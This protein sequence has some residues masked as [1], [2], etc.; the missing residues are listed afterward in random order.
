MF[1]VYNILG[2]DPKL[3][4][5]F[6]DDPTVDY[7]RPVATRLKSLG[8]RG[9]KGDQEFDTYEVLDRQGW[10]DRISREWKLDE[11]IRRVA[12]ADP[13]EFEGCDH[14]QRVKSVFLGSL[15][16]PS[17]CYYL[18]FA[19]SNVAGDCP[20]C[21]GKGVFDNPLH[22]P[23][24]DQQVRSER[25]QLTADNKHRGLF[26]DWPKKAQRRARSLD[27]LIAH[28][29]PTVSCPVCN[30]SGSKSAAEDEAW[31]EAFEELL[32]EHDLSLEQGLNGDPCDFFVARHVTVEPEEEEADV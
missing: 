30:G 23:H 16:N 2:Y 21:A 10:K 28:Y 14:D 27:R 7:G 24:V 20:V 4:L 22:N 19:C 15:I 12:N 6:K 3:V 8:I 29:G 11:I 31:R 26:I 9:P 13:E 18:P 5:V 1:V 32:G 25:A 17:G